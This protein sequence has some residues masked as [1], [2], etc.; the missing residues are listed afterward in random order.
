MRAKG[1]NA[2]KIKDHV[3]IVNT[4]TYHNH[5]KVMK[6]STPSPINRAS[7]IPPGTKQYPWNQLQTS[8]KK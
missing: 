8:R 6:V 5:Q 3:Q 2:F 4:K 7:R 1:Q